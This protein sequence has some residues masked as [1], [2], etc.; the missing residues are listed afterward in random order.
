MNHPVL[1]VGAGP[2]GM[3][4][5]L[6]VRAHGL[7][8]T[9]LE[10]DRE[11]RERPGSRAIFL[12]RESLEHLESIRRGPRMAAGAHGHR[13][14]DEEDVLRR[15]SRVRAD[16]SA[17]GPDAG[18][19]HSTNLSQVEIER[20]LLDACKEGGITF[21][22]EQELES[23][24]SSPDGVLLRTTS[25]NE[26]R[27]DRTSSAPMER[28][29]SCDRPPASTSKDLASRTPSSSST[30]PRTTNIRCFPSA[31][32]TTSILPSADATSCSCRSQVGFVQTSSYATTTTRS[33]STITTG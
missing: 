13:V 20:V 11:G 15:G 17:C 21:A 8:V 9:V 32:T 22:W 24:V 5:A 19:P 2:V 16:V 6:A 30:S 27:S 23:C 7:P 18:L 28:G 29:R 4:A 3:T 10:A 1:V 31:S 26:W 14:D 25:G 33:S 12:H